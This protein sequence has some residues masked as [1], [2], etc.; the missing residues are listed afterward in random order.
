MRAAPLWHSGGFRRPTTKP[1]AKDKQGKVE[2]LRDS[3]ELSWADLGPCRE[4]RS[5]KTRGIV[6]V[7]CLVC[8]LVNPCLH[9]FLLLLLWPWPVAMTQFTRLPSLTQTQFLFLFLP[10][11]FPTSINAYV[12]IWQK[13]KIPVVAIVQWPTSKITTR[14]TTT[15]LSHLVNRSPSTMSQC[16]GSRGAGRAPCCHPGCWTSRREVTQEAEIHS[17]VLGLFDKN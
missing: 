11:P 15:I 3:S 16:S 5:W 12:N 6:T 17:L 14:S 10:I 1:M 8:L 13:R 9:L 7:F 4:V 2:Q